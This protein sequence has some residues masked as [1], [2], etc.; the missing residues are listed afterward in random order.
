MRFCELQVKS[1]AFTFQLM[2]AHLKLTL[3]EGKSER[4]K[5]KLSQMLNLCKSKEK[6]D[7]LRV[8]GI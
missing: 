4:E 7:D 6:R 5:E 8:D 1:V 2:C 3:L